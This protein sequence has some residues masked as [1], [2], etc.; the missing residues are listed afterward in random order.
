MELEDLRKKI[1]QIDSRLVELINERA[2]VVVD[3]GK[4]KRRDG[5]VPVYAPDR[6]S[7]V[8]SK[9]C[10]LN[11][12]PLPD[13]TLVAVWRELMSGSF[14]I[15]RPLRISFLGPEGSY[16][17]QASMK[18]F[19]QSVDYV[20]LADIRGVFDEVARG[21]CDFGMVPV[22]NSSG[23]GV[24]ETLDAFLETRIMICAEMEMPIHHNLLA[25]C[26]LE[27]IEK[28]YSKPEVF[29]QCRNWI[30]ENHFEG[31]I[32]TE[33]STARAAE[34]AA[35]SEKCAAI[36]SSLAGR[37]YGLNVLYEKIED[38]PDNV[39]RFLIIS[40]RDT[41]KTGDDK[42]AVVFTTPH[43]PGALF[44]VL[45]V[46]DKYDIN[47]T[48]IESRPNKTRNWEY[49]FFA[50]INGHKTDENIIKALEKLH[51]RTI[52]VQILGSFPRYTGEPD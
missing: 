35:E 11:K 26:R 27:E 17:H 34:L 4:L 45:G 13:K 38:K 25:K 22:E 47:L 7:Q 49:H 33:A 8:L 2:K 14:F 20:P 36:G 1:D 5:S 52:Q 6:E 41:P 42:T 12:G 10:E 19:G 43:K 23:G 31:K 37:I 40:S 15:E 28:I 32:I 29:A 48:R 30:T 50:D 9:I 46:F 44:D 18:K 3:V 39:T 21:Q 16:S 51:D 24:V